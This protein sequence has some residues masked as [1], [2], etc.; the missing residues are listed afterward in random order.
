MCT[1]N[2]S[3]PQ[4]SLMFESIY[5][6]RVSHKLFQGLQLYN[7][8]A[9]CLACVEEIVGS[10]KKHNNPHN[11]PIEVHG[12]T[13]DR[14][15]RRPEVEEE[16]YQRK[17][18]GKDVYAI[19][20]KAWDFPRAPYQ[21]CGGARNLRVPLPEFGRASLFDNVYAPTPQQERTSEEARSI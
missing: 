5:T 10:G 2:E 14:H 7:R 20:Y 12:E 3:Q 16:D 15:S 8:P 9:I 6:L 17:Y 1:S 18:A 11:Q 13:R 21:R 4:R 19:A